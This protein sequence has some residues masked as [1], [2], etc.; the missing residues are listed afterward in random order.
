MKTHMLPSARWVVRAFALYSNL[1]L[2]D[3]FVKYI[4]LPHLAKVAA[5]QVFCS[6]IFIILRF[7]SYQI[8][9]T[10]CPR[11]HGSSTSKPQAVHTQAEGAEIKVCS[12]ILSFPTQV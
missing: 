10:N 3:R 8:F 6:S 2:D 5:P 1:D 7:S 9:L 4:S 12:R 11:P